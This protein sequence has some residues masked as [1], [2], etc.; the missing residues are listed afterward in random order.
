M[1][2]MEDTFEDY[3]KDI[4]QVE[5][6]PAMGFEKGIKAIREQI[7]P[8]LKDAGFSDEEIE[9]IIAYHTHNLLNRTMP[10]WMK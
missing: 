3:Q 1:S 4:Y 8:S 6:K 9:Y 10:D 2:G 5:H 7:L